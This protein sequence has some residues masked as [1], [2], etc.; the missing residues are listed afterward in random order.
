MASKEVK[1]KIK[2]T[3]PLLLKFQRITPAYRNHAEII[4]DS[5]SYQLDEDV[6]DIKLL[7]KLG[8]LDA[9][10]GI[11]KLTL[12]ITD[13]NAIRFTSRTSVSLSN[14]GQI[15][16][17]THASART[18]YIS[19]EKAKDG[20]CDVDPGAKQIHQSVG[21]V[22]K[23]AGVNTYKTGRRKSAIVMF[24]DLFGY[25]FVN[26]EKLADAFSQG[27]QTTVLTPDYINEDPIST[28]VLGESIIEDWLEKHPPTDAC[29]IA[30]KF[31]ST[32]KGDYESIQVTISFIL[33]NIRLT[34]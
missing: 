26:A 21:H 7:L 17:D 29:H 20:P 18:F 4:H 14:R 30:D 34:N 6:G 33:I 2:L 15:D 25:T 8:S 11:Y 22:E 31:I 3:Y 13:K 32:I 24:T 5:F 10:N 16:L 28:T 23:I 9:G 19:S 1:A 27:T 12:T